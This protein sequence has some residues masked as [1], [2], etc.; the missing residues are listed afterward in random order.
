MPYVLPC[1]ILANEEVAPDHYRIR[2]HTPEI[3]GE[4]VPAQFCMI[5]VQEG[6]YPLLRR[7]MS[8]EQIDEDSVTVLYKI[9][10]EGTRILSRQRAGGTVS[11]QG[12]LG[13]GFPVE[14]DFERHILVAGGIGIAPFPALARALIE[15]LSI[16][17]EVVIAARTADYILCEDLFR[18]LGCTVHVATDDGSA[19]TKGYAAQ[20]LEKLE[21][22][23]RDRVY[24]CG[25][26]IM[27]STTSDAA[28]AS[29]ANCLVALEAQMACGDGA[30]LGC[31]VESKKVLEGEKMVRVCCDGPVF[32]TTLI[33]WQAHNTAYDR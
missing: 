22:G 27:M 25:P 12:P 18:E 31:V 19:G 2:F 10:G 20:V 14:P 4:A 26:M 9:E 7:P 11:V 3:A 23:P 8:F 28:V 29:S 16:T 15:E 21:P 5:Q 13:R 30:C 24:V 32:D 17:P 33:D 6:Y 1:E